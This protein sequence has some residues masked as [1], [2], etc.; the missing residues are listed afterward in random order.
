MTDPA[1]ELLV[2]ARR[3]LG[4]TQRELSRR[5]GTSSSNTHYWENGQHDPSLASLRAWAAALGYDVA[6]IPTVRN[7][8]RDLVTTD[9]ASARLGVPANVIASWNHHRRITP[10]GYL[11]GRGPAAPQYR[12]AE[13]VPL[14]EQ[15]RARAST[16]RSQRSEDGV[17]NE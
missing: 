5:I 4:L 10:V 14:A 7:P 1:V 9:E 16:R 13:L 11:R 15:W 6:L 8:E 2:E 3:Q 17:V 12:L